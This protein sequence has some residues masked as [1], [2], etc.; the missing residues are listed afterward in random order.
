MRS[1]LC[2]VAVICWFTAFST[3][4]PQELRAVTGEQ[5]GELTQSQLLDQLPRYSWFRVRLAHAVGKQAEQPYMG[6]MRK[7]GVRRAVFETRAVWQRRGPDR[8]SVVRRMYYKEYDRPH[9]QIIDA[10]T[11]AEIRDSGLEGLLDEVALQRVRNAKFSRGIDGPGPRKGQV[12]FSF[13]EFLDNGWIPPEPTF[14]HALGKPQAD[15]LSVAAGVGDEIELRRLLG[16]RNYSQHELTTALDAAVRNYD[17][18]TSVIELLIKAGGDVNARPWPDGGTLLMCAIGHP[19]NVNALL[20]LGADV[21][22][23]DRQR[24]TALMH[25][26]RSGDTASVELLKAAGERE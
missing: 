2:S 16:L 19:S 12:L 25:A 7:A 21:N 13:V 4:L 10:G 11:L 23:R 22:A 24:Q 18:N 6:L 20:T 26:T 17:D 9:G 15:P 5:V 1:I 8:V 3:A 14:V